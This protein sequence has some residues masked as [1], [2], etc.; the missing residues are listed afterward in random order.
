MND[1]CD[2]RLKR[3]T[4]A[5]YSIYSCNGPKYALCAENAL[6]SNS[7]SDREEVNMFCVSISI[8]PGHVSI[9]PSFMTIFIILYM[10]ILPTLT[11]SYFKLLSCSKNTRIPETNIYISYITKNKVFVFE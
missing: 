1:L 9:V 11:V 4:R 8:F 5:S 6:D 10:L 7:Q 2:V 3:L